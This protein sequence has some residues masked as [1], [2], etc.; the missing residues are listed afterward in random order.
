M[1]AAITGCTTKSVFPNLGQK[2]LIIK[3]LATADSGDTLDV[4]DTTVTGGEV[5][6][7][8]ISFVTAFDITGNDR[9]TATVSGTTIT[10]DAGGSTTDHQYTLLVMGY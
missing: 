10:I 5:I 2:C 7:S 9:V 3:T 8:G 4:S 1:T 6:S